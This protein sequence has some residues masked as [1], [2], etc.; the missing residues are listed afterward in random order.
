M[1]HNCIGVAYDHS[2]P[3]KL[4][5]FAEVDVWTYENS[6]AT[7]S[8]L[9]TYCHMSKNLSS[10]EYGKSS[11]PVNAQYTRIYKFHLSLNSSWKHFNWRMCCKQFQS[12]FA[13]VGRKIFA[14][15]LPGC[16]REWSWC[17]LGGKPRMAASFRQMG[18]VEFVW[19]LQVTTNWI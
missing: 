13:V 6:G 14:Y 4:Y 2:Y 3:V 1:E 5:Y 15:Y 8:L 12:G 10:F 16:W 11:R 19:G 9:A 18:W 17:G 7:W